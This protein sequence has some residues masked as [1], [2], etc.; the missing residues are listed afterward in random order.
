[1]KK[2]EQEIHNFLDQW[3]HKTVKQYV[4]KMDGKQN[5]HLHDLIVSGVEKPLLKIVLEVSEGNQTRA[6]TILG[7]NRNTLRKK[8]QDYSIKCKNGT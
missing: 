5:G 2:D 8:I 1:M 4:E 6:A 7:I 3:L